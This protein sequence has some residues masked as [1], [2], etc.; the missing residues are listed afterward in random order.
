[1]GYLNVIGQAWIIE[2]YERK[3]SLV[4][5]DIWLFIIGRVNDVPGLSGF[6]FYWLGRAIKKASPPSRGVQWTVAAMEG[7]V[8]IVEE[9][10]D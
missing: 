1:M 5:S 9:I 8:N 6:L 3:G 4:Y 10:P 7:W 2:L